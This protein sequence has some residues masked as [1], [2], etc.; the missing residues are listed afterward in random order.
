MEQLQPL[1]IVI[2]RDVGLPFCTFTLADG[3]TLDLEPDEAREWCKSRGADTDAVE[4]VLDY[5]WNFRVAKFVI[6]KPKVPQEHH[7]RIDPLL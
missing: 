1:V 3:Q 7:T 6:N 4:S 2:S 5:V